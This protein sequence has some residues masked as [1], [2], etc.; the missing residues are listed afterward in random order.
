VPG[1]EVKFLLKRVNPEDGKWKSITVTLKPLDYEEEI[2]LKTAKIKESSFSLTDGTVITG[3]ELINYNN[4]VFAEFSREM[5]TAGLSKKIDYRAGLYFHSTCYN[6]LRKAN[7][8]ERS[9]LINSALSK[10][11]GKN[12]ESLLIETSYGKVLFQVGD[13][14]V[15]SGDEIWTE[16]ISYIGK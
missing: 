11:N 9:V 12:V 4:K 5:L 14:R 3:E 2:K 8:D 10:T 6:A 13:G 1:K 16:A 7:K 15:L